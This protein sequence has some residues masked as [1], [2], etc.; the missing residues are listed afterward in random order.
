MAFS[1]Y[2]LICML[3]AGAYASKFA[4]FFYEVLRMNTFVIVNNIEYLET[5]IIYKNSYSLIL[6]P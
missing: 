5:H 4:L 1:T 2:V 3:V 6:L